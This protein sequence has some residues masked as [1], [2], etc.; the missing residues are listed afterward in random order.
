MSEYI[1]SIS[2][3]ICKNCGKM[4]RKVQ[5]VTPTGK[6]WRRRI[7][8]GDCQCEEIAPIELRKGG[9]DI[10]R[11]LRDEKLGQIHSMVQHLNWAEEHDKDFTRKEAN[12][13]KKELKEE[14]KEA[15]L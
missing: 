9:V 15:G 14:I 6:E 7:E 8:D 11:I 10:G 2:G 13:W 3:R 4:I 12:F 5:V 1:V